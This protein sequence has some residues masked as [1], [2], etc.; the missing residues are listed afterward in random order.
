MQT[1]LKKL[2]NVGVCQILR[3]T[4]EQ[5]TKSV[6]GKV[7]I[8]SYDSGIR[9]TIPTKLKENHSVE[10]TDSDY[11]AIHALK[12]GIDVRTVQKHLGHSSLEITM[13]YLQLMDED[14]KEGYQRF[15]VEG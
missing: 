6:T 12:S 8:S 11:Q 7:Y 2:V 5:V 9:R 1:R 14:V 4:T 13:N 3:R 10:D 15:G